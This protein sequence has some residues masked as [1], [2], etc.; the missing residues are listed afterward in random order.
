MNIIKTDAETYSVTANLFPSELSHFIDHFDKNAGEC[1]R[2][3]DLKG[4]MR[5]VDRAKE[6]KKQQ[7]I[8][9]GIKSAEQE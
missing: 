6:I 4:A 9:L 5:W 8:A 2:K 3:N 1:L 7:D